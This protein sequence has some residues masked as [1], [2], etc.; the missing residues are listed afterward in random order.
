MTDRLSAL[1]VV[2]P[3]LTTL[4]LG[5]TNNEFVGNALFPTVMVD[6]E[7]SKIPKFSKDEFRILNTKRSIRAQSNTANPDGITTIPLNTEE[8]DLQHPVDYREAREAIFDAQKH[9]MK[10]SVTGIDLNREYEQA[11]LATTATNYAADSKAQIAAGS[12]WTADGSDPIAV[13]RQARSA[14]RSKTAKYP[15]TMVVG[16][17]VYEALEQNKAVLDRIKV[18]QTKVASI[19]LLAQVFNIEKIVVGMAA[20]VDDAG[21]LN[22]IWGSNV[23]LAYVRPTQQGINDNAIEPSFGYNF[24]RRDG[25]FVDRYT[26]VGGKIEYVRATDNYQ[27]LIVGADAGYLIQGAI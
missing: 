17:K 25:F 1:R 24:R 4:A 8:Y 6:K 11:K 3:V 5:L 27:S 13:V 16:A 2:D 14:I 22:D 18:T 19:E 10:L 9:A 23:V 7:A 26:A 20:Y 12:K 15:N 21:N